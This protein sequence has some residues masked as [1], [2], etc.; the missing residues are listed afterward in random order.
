MEQER[1]EAEEKEQRNNQAYALS[2]SFPKKLDLQS[3]HM[4][5]ERE[6]WNLEKVQNDL[7]CEL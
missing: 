4:L 3:A 2:L 1:R 7:Q 6:N 5:L